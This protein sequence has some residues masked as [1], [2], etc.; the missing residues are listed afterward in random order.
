MNKQI[1]Q[2]KAAI[3]LVQKLPDI[4]GRNHSVPEGLVGAI[5]VK[6]GTLSDS[7]LVEGGGL[8]IDYRPVASHAVHRIVIGSNDVAMWVEADF[9]LAQESQVP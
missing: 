9:P 8:V 6:I 2:L 4:F 3:I 5:I 7:R 1:E